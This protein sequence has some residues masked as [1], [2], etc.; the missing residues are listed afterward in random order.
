MK[1]IFDLNNQNLG[2]DGKIMAALDKLAS[3][4]RYLIW[5]QSKKK[6]LSPIQIQLLIFLKH[7]RSEQATV[8]YL[9]KEFHV[10]KPTISDAV[11][12]LF[13]KKLVVKKENATDA[14]SYALKI[15][16]EGEII[17]QETESFTRPLQNIL[18]LEEPNKKEQVWEL[19]SNLLF[20]LKKIDIISVNRMCFS[21]QFYTKK[22]EGHYCNLMSKILESVEIRMDCPEHIEKIE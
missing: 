17:V 1:S 15:T 14:R 10:T 22:E 8:S 6:G 20:Q 9:A 7:H 13:Q 18:R 11:K 5:E 19:L 4:Q 3:I 21:C 2:V 12:I 16:E